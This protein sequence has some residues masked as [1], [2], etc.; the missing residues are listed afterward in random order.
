MMNITRQLTLIVI[1]FGLIGASEPHQPSARWVVS[2]DDAQCGA[3]R[4]YGTTENPLFL[5]LKMPPVGEVVQIAMVTTDKKQAPKQVDAQIIFDQQPALR[6]S[7]LVFANAQ[8]ERV[9]LINLP[10]RDFTVARTAKTISIRTRG[11][12]NETFALSAVDLLMKVM[13]QCVAG[14][15]KVWNV[16]A[17]G[18]PLSTLRESAQGNL[19]GLIRD[20]EY[21]AMA[22][23]RGQS[24]TVSLALLINESGR[25][26]DCALVGTSGAASLDAQTCVILTKRAQFKPAIGLDGKPAKSSYFQRVNWITEKRTFR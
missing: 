14:L 5:T 20:D 15:R 17:P 1:G 10:A 6:T 4:N 24:G 21:P 19:Q 18:A 9:H 2:F 22:I 26:A 25:I 11:S 16:G 7:M 23:N 3:S 12:P 8:Q 13:D